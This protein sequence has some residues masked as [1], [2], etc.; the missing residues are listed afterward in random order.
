MGWIRALVFAAGLAI[1]AGAAEAQW[2]SGGDGRKPPETAVEIQLSFAPVVKAVAPAVVNVYANRAVAQRPMSPFFDDPL[3]RKFF[4]EEFG[5]GPAPRARMESSLGSGVI[6]DKSGI[7]VTNH[8]VVANAT[9]VKISLADKREFDCDI[10]LKDER[11]DLAVLR[12]R[13]K[14][15]FPVAQLG[16]SEA[17]EV[18]D[19]VLAI[20][21]PFGVG[22]TV[23]QGIVSA[24]ARTQVGISD[25]QFF[26]Q[27]DAAINPGNSGGALVD[28]KGRLVGINTAIFSRSGG[29]IGIGFA[30]PVN[31]VK[32]VIESSR[33]G[34]VVRRPWLGADLQ[35]VTPDIADGLGLDRPRGA[36]VAQIAESSPA[37]AAG[38]RTGDLILSVDGVT[39]DDPDAVNYR[40]ATRTVGGKVALIIRR[41]GKDR[42]LELAL[43]AAPE[44]VPR[45]ERSIDGYSPFGGARV[46]NLSPAVAEELRISGGAT[47]VAVKDVIP[48]SPANRVGLQ[49]GDVVVEVNGERIATTRDLD[50]AAQAEPVVWRIAIQRDGRTMRMVFR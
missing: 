20:G 38:L 22:Q 4:G 31:M 12:V 46:I 19:L 41:A 48:G 35:K 13:E 44:T 9:D 39:V 3:F 49:K 40:L 26:I 7:I 24:L 36:L 2:F 37:A 17:L 23:T 28:M 25:Y 1:G 32:V 50:K 10:I 18:G 43:A 8:H 14:G 6:V 16:D 15:V 34:G 47:G 42:S 33:S 45:D 21:N 5:A 30:I 29:S 27:T 11:T